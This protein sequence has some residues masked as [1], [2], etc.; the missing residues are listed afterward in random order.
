MIYDDLEDKSQ[1][2]AIDARTLTIKARWALA[3]C[4][5]PAGLAIDVAHR[6]L[7][8]GCGNQK[9]AVVD[10]DSGQ[11]VTTLPIGD[12]VDATAFDPVTNLIFIPTGT[13]ADGHSRR[14]AQC[15]SRRGKCHDAER[16]AHDGCGYADAQRFFSD[17]AIRDRSRGDSGTTTPAPEHCAGDVYDFSGI[18]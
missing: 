5:E 17:C 11:V 14:L 1:L 4:E 6:R 18:A 10:A 16:R 13:D 3:P 7:F 15:L 12:H 8:A 2:A 9:L